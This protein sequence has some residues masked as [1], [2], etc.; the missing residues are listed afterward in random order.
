MVVGAAAVVTKS[1]GDYCIVAG[2]PARLIRRYRP[3]EGEILA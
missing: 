1:F 2:N 3:D